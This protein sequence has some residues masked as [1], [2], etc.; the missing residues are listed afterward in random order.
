MILWF[1]DNGLEVDLN[2]CLL[3]IKIEEQTSESHLLPHL[4]WG[5]GIEQLGEISE[6]LRHDT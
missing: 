6:L 5:K 4:C 1:Y 2:C 3:C